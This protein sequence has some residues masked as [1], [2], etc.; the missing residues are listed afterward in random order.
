MH[1]HLTETLWTVIAQS[2]SAF[3]GANKK[4][5]DT[6]LLAR[7]LDEETEEFHLPK[8]DTEVKKK[9]QA[10]RIEKKLTQAQLAQAINEQPRVVQ[11][12]ESGKAVPNQQVLAKLERILGVK[13]RGKIK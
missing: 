4:T 1:R 9:I 5:T 8:V 12:Y 13:L 3:A 10:A 6:G 2:A 11:E 7:K